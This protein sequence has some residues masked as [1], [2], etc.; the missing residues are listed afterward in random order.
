MVKYVLSENL[1]TARPDDFMATPVDVK[2]FDR[3]T[4]VEMMLKRGT[5]LTKTDILAVLNSL[6]EVVADIV[7]DGGAVNM[8]LFNTSFS[9]SGVFDGAMDTFDP[10]RHRLY[11]NLNKGTLLR[12]VEKQVKTSK[13]EMSAAAPSVVEV[14]DVL[15]GTSNEKLTPMG[16]IQVFGSGLRIEGTEPTVGLWFVPAE[17]AQPPIKANVMVSNKPSSLTAMVPALDAGTYRIRVATQYAGSGSR[18]LKTP[19]ITTWEKVFVVG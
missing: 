13:T 2:S 12:D 19:R 7:K 14:R 5:L 15:S 3:D 11:V 16:V 4:I 9:I 1:L 6:E 17:G 18:L 10:N 8:P